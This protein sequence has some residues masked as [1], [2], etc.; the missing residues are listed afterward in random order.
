[1]SKRNDRIRESSLRYQHGLGQHFLY[2][3]DLL[4][5]LVRLSGVGPEDDVLEIGPGVGSMT[6]HLCAAAHQV[7][8]VELDARLIPLLQGFMADYGNFTLVQGDIMTV[9]LPEI[10]AGLRKPL[11]VVA[12]IPYY[13]TTPLIE[14]LLNCGLPIQRMALMVQQEVA[15][16]LLSDP[17]KP[18]WGPLAAR[19]RYQFQA[20]LLMEVPAECFTPPPK[21][22]SAFV[23]LTALE[24]PTVKVADEKQFFRM[25]SAAFALRRKTMTNC[26]IAAFHLSRAEAETLMTAAGVDTRARGEQLSMET[27]AKLSDAYTALMA[28]GIAGETEKE[29]G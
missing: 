26:L 25:I 1:M 3:D 23:L 5:T 19:C 2:D 24:A 22:D 12:N 18:G 28:G 14:L 6:K 29:N 20:E 17:G 9:H 11:S 13:I 7:L 27:L 21:V 4:A 8:S 10:T 16:K 15:E